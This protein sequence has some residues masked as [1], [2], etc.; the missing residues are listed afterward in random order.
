MTGFY[1]SLF[2]LFMNLVLLILLIVQYYQA[3]VD[4][5]RAEI[6][7]WK[8]KAGGFDQGAE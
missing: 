4:A 7:V 5:A 1:L 8:R 2:A 3:R 6:E